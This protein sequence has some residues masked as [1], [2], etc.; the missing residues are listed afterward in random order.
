LC[1]FHCTRIRTLHITSLVSIQTLPKAY[2]LETASLILFLKPFIIHVEFWLEGQKKPLACCRRGCEDIKM[3]LRK[4]GW[5]D[6]GWINLA[7][8]KDGWRALVNTLHNFRIP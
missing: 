6:M 1:S 2:L 8:D 5:G 7:Q 4:I 3:D